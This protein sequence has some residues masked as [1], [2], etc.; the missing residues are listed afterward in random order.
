MTI[1]AKKGEDIYSFTER[2]VSFTRD[3]RAQGRGVEGR[4]NGILLVAHPNSRSS[5]LD[6]IYFLK[7]ENAQLKNKYEEDKG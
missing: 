2:L 6:I 5:D 3:F 4:F 7:L 1:D